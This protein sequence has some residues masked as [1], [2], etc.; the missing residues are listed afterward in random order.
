VVYI[1][2]YEDKIKDPLNIPEHPEG[3]FLGSM[4]L[5]TGRSEIAQAN[6]TTF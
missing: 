4:E 3:Q 2:A 6:Y 5:S 1:S